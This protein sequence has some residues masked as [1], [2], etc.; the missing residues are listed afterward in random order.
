MDREIIRKKLKHN[1][2]VDNVEEVE[3][4]LKEEGFILVNSVNTFFPNNV[5]SDVYDYTC[6]YQNPNTLE[7][8]AISKVTFKGYIK[9]IQEV[10][11]DYIR[12]LHIQNPVR[13]TLELMEKEKTN[14]YAVEITRS[15]W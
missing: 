4:F 7:F 9:T 11:L 14:K 3:Q 6:L 8:K 5:A 10:S 15:E 1:A 13:T 12:H 2:I